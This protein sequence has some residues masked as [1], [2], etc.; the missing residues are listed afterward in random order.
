M[1][2]IPPTVFHPCWVLANV[3]SQPPIGQ[4]TSAICRIH[5]PHMTYPK[6]KLKPST[7]PGWTQR[8]SQS[9]W[10]WVLFFPTLSPMGR[11]S[12]YLRKPLPN[13]DKVQ[14]WRDNI[15]WALTMRRHSSQWRYEM[16]IMMS[17]LWR[18]KV[19]RKQLA[20]EA[21]VGRWW[22][23]WM[24]SR[25]HSQGHISF[26]LSVRISHFHS[27]QTGAVSF[28]KWVGYRKIGL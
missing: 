14:K 5:S 7:V 8:E 17:I 27:L 25:S 20:R 28:S 10:R 3:L 1:E 4:W 26:A 16:G 24:V 6:D 15:S 21:I 22:C 19:A 11:A 23:W 12:L 18:R 2:K 13:L 9:S